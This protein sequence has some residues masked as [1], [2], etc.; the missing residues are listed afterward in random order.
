MIKY[1]FFPLLLTLGLSSCDCSYSYGVYVE[2]ATGEDLVVAFK[3][4]TSETEEKINLSDGE[5]KMIIK[6]AEIDPQGD[7]SGTSSNHCKFV[8]AYV[9]GI[10]SDTIYSKKEWC[11]DKV[12][13]EKTDF[14][15]GEFIIKYTSDD[16]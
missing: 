15:E 10:K 8:A 9:Y 4:K 3:S 11:S 2:N 12:I 5:K 7:C 16:F 6:N 14:Q 1:I 13:F